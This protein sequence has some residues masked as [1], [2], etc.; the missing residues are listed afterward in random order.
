MVSIHDDLNNDT[1]GND[2][3]TMII[4]TVQE[5]N[6][7]GKEVKLNILIILAIQKLTGHIDHDNC[8]GV[9]CEEVE[10]NIL[11]MLIV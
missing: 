10:L 2:M 7:I 5:F 3:T 1:D 11:I 4:L 6:V 8:S 9:P